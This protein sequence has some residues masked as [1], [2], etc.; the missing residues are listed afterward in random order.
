MY[1]SR[2]R[3]SALFAVIVFWPL[4]ASAQTA[5]G[6]TKDSSLL[7]TKASE[8][9]VDGSFLA[10]IKARD[11]TVALLGE[12]NRIISYNDKLRSGF[13]NSVA[14]ATYRTR[15]DYLKNVDDELQRLKKFEDDYSQAST[16][17]ACAGL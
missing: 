3:F 2:R 11:D 13:E 9:L 8:E 17:P 5:V 12:L 15:D 14:S 1:P 16:G 10:L 6:T 7:G 4:T